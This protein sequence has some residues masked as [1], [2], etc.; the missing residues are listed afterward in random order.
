[1]KLYLIVIPAIKILCKYNDIL[2]SNIAIIKFIP[3]ESIAS[4]FINNISKK[5]DLFCVMGVNPM[6][7]NVMVFLFLQTSKIPMLFCE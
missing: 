1:M 5:Q 4:N 6:I 2:I 7:T 3:A